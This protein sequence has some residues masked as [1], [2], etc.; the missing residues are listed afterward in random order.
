MVAGSQ[1]RPLT[2]EIEYQTLIERVPGIVYIAEPGENGEWL[3]V[4]PQI[5]SI[6]GYTPEQWRSKPTLWCERLHEQDRARVLEAEAH[7]R[8]SG[9]PLDTEYRMLAHDGSVVW[10]RDKASLV[11]DQPSGR[12][13]LQG[14]LI[15]VT[16]QRLS[17]EARRASEAEK[18]AVIES[19]IDCIITVDGDG[20]V[21]DFNPAAERTFGFSREQAIGQE[22]AELIIP[23]AFREAHRRALRRTVETGESRVLGERMELLGMRADGS[24]FPVEVALTQISRDPPLFTGYLRDISKRKKAEEDLRE[25]HERLQ[26]VIDNSPSMIAAKDRSGRYLFVNREFERLYTIER[27][28]VVGRTDEDL[29]PPHV[30]T[31]TSASDQ[32]VIEWGELVKI[33]EVRRRAGEDRTYLTQKFPLRDSSGAI[34]AVCSI[35]TDITERKAREEALRAEIGWST[36][37]RAAI[38]SDRLVLHA[39]P[40]LD[41]RTG[42][43]FQHE[44]LVRMRGD[45]GEEDLIPPA[46][47]LPPAERFG[48]VREIDRWVVSQAMALAKDRRVEVNLSG[49]SIGDQALIDHIE[50]ELRRHQADPGNVIFEITETAAAE[51]IEAASAFVRK[52][53]DAGC[54][55]A[56]DDFGT[57]FGSF[58][59]LK[60]L[61]VT[62]L[63]IDMEFVRELT[64]S[65]S[66]HK[67][68]K[69]IVQVASNFGMETVAEGVEDDATLA[70]LRGLGVDYA[71]GFAIGRPGPLPPLEG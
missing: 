53:T 27:E 11:H 10:L 42:H 62:Y 70:L 39:Q 43:I 13:L 20:R 61:P 56:L 44:L 40:I 63:K 14:V 66:D 30:A 68:V 55:F 2:P 47:F 6:L 9:L 41:L 7:S 3:Y 12:A 18:S 37:I 64:T 29:F 22:L 35:S 46:V 52:L 49:K 71:Q 25:G 36:R 1:T 33:E 65:R 54:G 21:R 48:L 17:E 38:E 26:A 5:E 59:Y 15:D 57:G 16:A 28:S 45:R 24:T 58:N 4:S 50:R 19:A 23:P 67:V 8:A 32:R 51:N 60:H 34:H 31:E 69:A